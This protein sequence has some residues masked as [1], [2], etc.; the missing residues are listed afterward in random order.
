MAPI[1]ASVV[2]FPP[3]KV[4]D[5][6]LLHLKESL[7]SIPET[8]EDL[9]KRLALCVQD[10]TTWL[11]E[12]QVSLLSVREISEQKELVLILLSKLRWIST[13]GSILSI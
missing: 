7:C 10:W 11:V 13:I 4:D 9:L 3:Q 1:T 12:E 5:E 2:G 6:R 8:S